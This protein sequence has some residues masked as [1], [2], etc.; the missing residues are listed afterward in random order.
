MTYSD[1][2]FNG[3]LFASDIYRLPPSPEVDQKWLDLGLNLRPHIIPA[4]RAEKAGLMP[5][6]AKRLDS[7][8]GGYFVEVEAIHHLHCLNVL[9]Q[10]VWFNAE[11]YRERKIGVWANFEPVVRLHVGHCIN[12]LRQQLMCTA[13]TGLFGQMLVNST[14]LRTFADFSTHNKCKDFDRVRTWAV[15]HQSRE[16]DVAAY[17]EGDLVIDRYP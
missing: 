2:R 16:G 3:S 17:P 11:Y 12:T 10:N 6:Q 1:V 15:E 7:Q 13:D 14:A 9:R 4:A 8:G 5:N